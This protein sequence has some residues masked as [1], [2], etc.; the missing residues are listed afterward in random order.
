LSVLAGILRLDGATASG[1]ALAAM[2]DA[3]A[4]RATGGV[5]TVLEGP[6]AMAAS[7][8]AWSADGRLCLALC[9]RVDNRD[10]L[11]AGSDAEIV[12]AAYERWGTRAIA[13]ILGDFALALFD[14][15]RGELVCAR[16]F[17]GKRPLYY[18]RGPGAF[19]WASEP[20]AVL[21]DPAIPRKPN[22]GMIGEHLAGAAHS[23]R[24][25]LF[26]GL[27]RLPPAHLLTV[28]RDG[29]VRVERYWSWDPD[30]TVRHADD[31]G[32]AEEF[33][34]LFTAAVAARLQSPHPVAAELSGGLDSSAVVAVAA[35]AG[36]LDVYSLVFPGSDSDETE[37][38]RAVAAHVGVTPFEAEPQPA[39]AALYED[40]VRR[41]LDLPEPPNMAMHRVLYDV[42][43]ARGTRVVLT[44][45]GGD[46]W[47]TGSPL[48]YADRLRALQLRGLRG[49]VAAQRSRWPARSA[50][51]QLARDGVLPLMPARMQDLVQRATGRVGVPEWMP[52]DFW[53]G[54]DLPERIRRPAPRGP[55]LAAAQLAA[56]L[57]DGWIVHVA[58][59]SERTLAALGLEGRGPLDDRRLVEF[60]LALPSTLRQRDGV[61]KWVVRAA[62]AGSL[63]E[64]VRTRTDKT[65]FR[66]VFFRELEAQGGRRLFENLAIEELGWVDGARLRRGYE[67]FVVLHR[68]GQG[69][70]LL[71]PLWNALSV[72]R[73]VRTALQQ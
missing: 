57:D 35:A 68:R 64:V 32:Y 34:E 22:V 46:E 8:V 56:A 52:E 55:R 47:F 48:A 2:T 54:L 41:Y 4:H 40:Q 45:K 38:I 20:Q 69:H 58:E 65:G 53:R 60:A 44:G 23:T 43:R 21:A 66:E 27:L 5:E 73:W 18:H 49:A 71:W 7:A 51:R 50:L 26:E 61:T 29:G 70:P 31:R 15:R 39:G 13:R 17:L 12:L 9:G 25:T 19:R 36:P 11:G 42:A 16:D 6:V 1:D 33:R 72:E 67:E 62:M 63:P 3:L 14:Q 28:S 37:H 24:E 10:E 30:R 59:S